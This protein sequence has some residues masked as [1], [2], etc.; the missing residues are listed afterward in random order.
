MNRGD[1]ELAKLAAI[2]VSGVLLLAVVSFISFKS[3]H[4]NETN[5]TTY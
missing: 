5:K 2:I 3:T 4:L 1:K